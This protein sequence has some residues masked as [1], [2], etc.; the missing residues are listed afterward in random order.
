MIMPISINDMLL[1]VCYTFFTDAFF[2]RKSYL[3][4]GKQIY[5][6]NYL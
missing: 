3:T 5:G 1:R 6:K 4:Y 2:T